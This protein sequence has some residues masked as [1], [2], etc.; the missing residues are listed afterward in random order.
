MN[1]T[2]TTT[3]QLIEAGYTVK[4][5]QPAKQRTPRKDQRR[6]GDLFWR[7]AKAF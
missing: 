1:F 4:K 5:L 2:T 7:C 6:R 3:K